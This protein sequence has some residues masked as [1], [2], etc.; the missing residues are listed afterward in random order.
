MLSE[1]LN[2]ETLRKDVFVSSPLVVDNAWH[3]CNNAC[4]FKL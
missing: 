2:D 4:V 3:I 1:S